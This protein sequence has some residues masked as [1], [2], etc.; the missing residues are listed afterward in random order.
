VR[1][2]CTPRTCDREVDAE[3]EAAPGALRLRVPRRCRPVAALLPD[4]WPWPNFVVGEL[5]QPV[6]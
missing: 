5:T 4:E 3:V 1:R 6:A 2:G